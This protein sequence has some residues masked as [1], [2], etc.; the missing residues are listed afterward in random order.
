MDKSGTSDPYVVLKASFNTQKFK[1]KI[2]YKNLLPQWNQEFIF[3]TSTAEGIIELQMFDKDMI[4]KDEFMGEVKL[5]LLD[6]AD[7]QVH[8]KWYPLENEPQ[9]KKIDPAQ[10]ELRLKIKF[11]GPHAKSPKGSEQSAQQTQQA[12]AKSPSQSQ[13]QTQEPEKPPVTTNVNIEE[14]YELGKI[15]GRGAFSVVKSGISKTTKKKCAVKCISKKLIDKKEMTLLER[16]I[17]IMRKLRHPHIIQLIEVVDTPD[18][19]YLALEYAS[20]G[21]LFD[22]IVNRGSYS[23]TD[24]AKLI[25]QILEAILYIHNH[26]IAHRDLK[27]ENLLLSNE[28]GEPEHVKIADFGLSKEFGV[29][30]MATSCGTPDY[31]A[32]EVLSGE[33]YDKEVDIWSIGV[34][35]YVLLCGFPPFYGET[36]KE[37][38]ENILTGNYDFPNPEWAGVSDDAK[39]FI[40]KMLVVNPEKRYT[41][42]QCL[43]DKWLMDL[44]QPSKTGIKRLETFSVA[45]FKEYTQKYKEAN[46]RQRNDD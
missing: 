36:Q 8:D 23:E 10:G 20:G 1:T 22:A 17:D 11:T 9:K 40:K 6:I 26:G 43:K 30:Q 24:A 45:K 5:N 31:V 13:S 46:P 29:E 28:N 4:Y 15:L 39:N 34:I 21:E 18:T 32:P 3:F 12:P 44:T 41:A 14:R 42:E 37:L 2:Q 38:F 25:K 7:G 33:I 27:P 16:E 19:L 35:T